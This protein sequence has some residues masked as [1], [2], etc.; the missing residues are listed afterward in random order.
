MRTPVDNAAAFP[1]GATTSATITILLNLTH[2][3]AGALA[4]AGS[5]G[6]ELPPRARVHA[7][8]F[9]TSR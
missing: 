8:F 3:T 7:Y 5:G 2:I 6:S 1:T 4:T 9:Y